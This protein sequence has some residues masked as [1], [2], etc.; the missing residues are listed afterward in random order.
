MAAII[1]PQNPTLNQEFTPAGS[2]VTYKWNGTYWQLATA[3]IANS[4]SF[5]GTASFV[6]NPPISSSYA[7]T[8]S[9]ALNGGGTG[10]T[11]TG[12]FTGSF[13]GSV[14]GSASYALTASYAMN[15]GGTGITNT[16]S[17]T[18]SF[19]GSVLGTASYA[20]NA[21]TSSFAITSSYNFITQSTVFTASYVSGSSVDGAVLSSSYALTASY[22]MNGGG[23][24]ITN[25]GSFTGSFTGSVLGSAS[26]A[27]TASFV[28]TAQTASFVNTARTASFVDVAQTA[29]FVNTA[30]TASWVSGNSVVGAVTSS[31]TSSF[32]FSASLA[33]QSTRAQFSLVS[34]IGATAGE[35]SLMFASTGA[36][37]YVPAYIETAGN[38]LR[39]NPSIDR[40]IVGSISASNGFTGSLFGTAQTASFISSFTYPGEIH[41]STG[42]GNDTTGNGTIGNPYQTLP[43]A[44]SVATSTSTIFIHPGTYTGIITVS[45]SHCT[46]TGY[47]AGG[48]SDSTINGSLIFK[49]TTAGTTTVSNLNIGTLALQGTGSV[50]VNSC[51]LSNYLYNT[52]SSGN[53]VRNTIINGFSDARSSSPT[54]S[55]NFDNSTLLGFTVGDG[56]VGS[57]FGNYSISNCRLR[58]D[59]V[60]AGDTGC[61]LVVNDTVI[62]G[63]FSGSF[64]GTSI[65]NNVA[66]RN[67]DGSLNRFFNIGSAATSSITNV[68]WD[69]S[70]GT[71]V[72]I[73]GLTNFR[74]HSF[75]NTLSATSFIG[76]ASWA[77]NAV[78][79]NFATTAQTVLGSIQTASL[80]FTASF[81]DTARTASFVNGSNV[82]GVIPSASI[83][84][85]ASWITGSGVFGIVSNAYTASYIEKSWMNA[86]RQGAATTWN[87]SVGG[88]NT[89]TM[90]ANGVSSGSISSKITY[91]ANIF[92]FQPG[93][94]DIFFTLGQVT[95]PAGFPDTGWMTYRAGF[96]SGV[97]DSSWASTAFVYG[98]T[99]ASASYNIPYSQGI[100]RLTATANLIITTTG[101]S[102]NVRSGGG[103]VQP[104]IG[105]GD[106]FRMIAREL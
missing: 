16:G 105:I 33:V 14:L 22:A 84:Q 52:I 94:Y 26:F 56:S 77:S 21:L 43:K 59:L 98:R 48:A 68:T 75:S 80:A 3:T 79:A 40:L 18:G 73:Q 20:T 86:Y 103:L 63:N 57:S 76:T 27:E 61:V 19:T 67:S 92:T 12:S 25:T 17:F 91:S 44:F 54:A 2:T 81:V 70:F 99:A 29:S 7:L 46:I 35:Y 9:F 89:Q 49:N 100:V 45:G 102:G 39:Y 32:S 65:L 36:T 60:N 71:T 41:V 24:G 53:I 10:I 30:R 95:F 31:L 83:A 82:V 58:S 51:T 1:F 42:S 74:Q 8:A 13:T 93:D 106:G 38:M 72:R 88:T 28:T 23:T 64:R 69:E 87:V 62:S 97:L 47:G 104:L 11:N 37:G 15:G 90:F 34:G 4:A 85:T 50:I 55:I 6:I 5:A 101:N 66:L 96:L 78:N